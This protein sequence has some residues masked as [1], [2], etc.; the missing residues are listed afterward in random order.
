M[1][2]RPGPD[3][4]W[5]AVASI[6]SK[7]STCLRRAVGCVLLDA[8]G[9][10][11]STGY[12]GVATGQP[13][14]NE[15]VMVVSHPIGGEVRVQSTTPNACPGWKAVSGT[16][17]D[18]CKAVHAEQ[19]ALLQCRDPWAIEVCYCTVSPCMTCI[20]LLMGTTCRRVIFLEEY[21]HEEARNWWLG[22]SHERSWTKLP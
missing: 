22:S 13:H 21:P 19:N 17:L 3:Q 5:L 1:T 7:R 14:C 10:V 15:E 12:N 16:G 8:R 4:T 9:H 11:L 6:I 20:K 2:T 18:N